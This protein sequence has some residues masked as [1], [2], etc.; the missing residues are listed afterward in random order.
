MHAS[1]TVV[2]APSGLPPVECAPWCEDGNGHADAV[3][4]EDQFCASAAEEV[5]L[6]RQPSEYPR[7]LARLHTYL[8]RE[9]FEAEPHVQV[10]LQERPLVDLTVDEAAA[11]AE[12]LLRLVRAAREEV[13]R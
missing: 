5:E 3:A 4:V 11:L 13:A 1:S 2:R 6:L 12:S 9:R 8:A 7:E 10:V